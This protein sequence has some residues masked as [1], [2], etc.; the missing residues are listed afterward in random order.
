[1]NPHF[2]LRDEK[3]VQTIESLQRVDSDGY[4]YYMESNWN[5]YNLTEPFSSMLDAGCSAFLAPNIEGE[6]LMYRNYDYKHYRGNDTSTPITGINVICRCS[7]PA[8]RYKSI[9]VADAFWL[10]FRNGSLVNGSA[11]D[12]RTDLSAFILLPYLC[13]DGMNEAGLSVSIMALLVKADWKEIDYNTYQ[14]LMDPAKMN[15]KLEKAGEE[16]DI[17]ARRNQIG[18]V[19][20]NE[21]DHRAWICE[22]PIVHTTFPGKPTVLHPVLM[23]MM[24]DNCATVAEAVGLAG[25]YNVAAPAPEMDFHIMV[26]DA[27]GACKILEWVDNQFHVVDSCHATNF[28]MSADDAFHGTCPRDEVLKAGLA[29]GQR[30][31]LRQDYGELAMRLAS[32]DPTTCSDLLKTQYSCVYNLAR[33]TMKIYSFGNFDQSWEY[34]L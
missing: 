8:A 26:A 12:G 7:N 9:G 19:A 17:W 16:P 30:N 13:M 18:S 3:Q 23:R 25:M 6:Y 28:R 24:L 21:V 5:Y 1:M 4:L 10:D 2:L 20:V 32:Q 27:S 11:D 33:H 22:K 34:T 14:D 29:V 15:Y 31:G